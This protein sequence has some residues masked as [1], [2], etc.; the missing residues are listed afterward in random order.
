MKKLK[1]KVVLIR[2]GETKWALA[3]LADG[4]TIEPD[5]TEW[6]YGRYNR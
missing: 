3:G 6:D 2:H 4:V 1:Q 5:L